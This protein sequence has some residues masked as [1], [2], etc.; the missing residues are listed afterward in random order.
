[1]FENEWFPKVS[2][3]GVSYDDFWKLNPHKINVM[4]KGHEEAIKERDFMM[5]LQGKYMLDALM[6]ALAHFGAGMSGKKSQA[7]YMKEPFLSKTDSE[8]VMTEEERLQKEIEQAIR[9]EELWI[10]ASKKKGLPETII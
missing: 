1:M 6:V 3:M 9:N 2:P 10:K 5:W 4:S 8:T 7:E